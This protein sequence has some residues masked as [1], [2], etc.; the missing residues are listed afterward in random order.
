MNIGS[1]RPEVQVAD[2]RIVILDG[3]SDVFLQ[4]AALLIK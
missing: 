3:V 1:N 2:S 4:V